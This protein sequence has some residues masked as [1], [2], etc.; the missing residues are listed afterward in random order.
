MRITQKPS[1]KKNLIFLYTLLTIALIMI[2][3][4]CYAYISKSAW[5]FQKQENIPTGMINYD[6]PTQDEIDS[7]QDAKERIL[8]NSTQSN[9][10]ESQELKPSNKKQV[11]VGVSY[12]DVINNNLEV[13]AFI[14]DV[15]SGSGTC[16][17][18]VKK[19]REV[20]TKSS[21]SFID[22]TSTICEPIYIPVSKLSSGTWDIT[23]TYSSTTHTGISSVMKVSVK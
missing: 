19:G 4:F 13:R 2:G 20:I 9:T 11:T 14:T 5:P 18:T 1:N 15:I 6:P 17:V 10:S 8:N 12:A 21:P 3:Y 7:S 16:T 22:A 23:V